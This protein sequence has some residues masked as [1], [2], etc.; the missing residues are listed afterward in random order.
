[1]SCKPI[2][3]GWVCGPTATEVLREESLGE[4][5]CFMCR[6]R[7]PFAEQLIADKEPTYYDPWFVVRCANGHP[8]GDLF[9]GRYREYRDIL[10]GGDA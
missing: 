3:G 2:P 6:K 10:D 5:W 9:P 1:M 7:V 4:R 8:D